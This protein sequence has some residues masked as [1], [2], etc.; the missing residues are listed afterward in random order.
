MALLGKFDA[1]GCHPDVTRPYRGCV[2]VP[3][4][5]TMS[6]AK[7]TLQRAIRAWL[8]GDAPAPLLLRRS[9]VCGEKSWRPLDE[10]IRSVTIDARLANGTRADALLTD[11]NGGTA[12][13]IQLDGGSRL[14]NRVDSRAGLPLIVLR[15]ET[16]A[17]EPERWRPV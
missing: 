16:L 17:D 8:D 5:P 12:L 13:V 2:I 14:A 6:S 10:R 9:E 7:R 15:A 1:P 3:S 11:A 4:P